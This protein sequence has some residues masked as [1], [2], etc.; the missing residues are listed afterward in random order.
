[1]VCVSHGN[2]RFVSKKCPLTSEFLKTNFDGA[3]FGESKKAGI[4]VVI[5]NFEGEVMAV[6]S[7]KIK[8]SPIVEIMEL[9]VA[10]RAVNIT[11]ETGFNKFVTK[12]DSKFVINS[13]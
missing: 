6:L 4:G 5:R 11:L 12:G 7:E 2:R 3:M 1:M 10:K 9:L 13:L 8:K